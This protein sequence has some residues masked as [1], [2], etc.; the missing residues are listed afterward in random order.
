MP[1]STRRPKRCLLRLPVWRCF[2]L[3]RTLGGVDG[4]AYRFS[5]YLIG[6]GAAAR[7]SRMQGVRAELP[8]LQK[9]ILLDDEIQ[10]QDAP[11]GLLATASVGITLEDRTSNRNVCLSLRLRRLIRRLARRPLC[12]PKCMARPRIASGFRE[13]ACTVCSNVS[14]P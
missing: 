1:A 2:V 9:A 14:G 3:K 10:M 12:V 11:Y 8:A 5:L 13:L 7:L 4:L 6:L